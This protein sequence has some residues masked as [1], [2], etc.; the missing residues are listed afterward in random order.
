MET[1]PDTDDP[2]LRALLSVATPSPDTWADQLER[3]ERSLAA[4][5]DSRSPLADRRGAI[6]AADDVLAGM[7]V[8]EDWRP[9]LLAHLNASLGDTTT[10]RRHLGDPRLGDVLDMRWGAVL[11]ARAHVTAGDTVGALP[12][13]G[14]AVL[15]LD[16]ENPDARWAAGILSGRGRL[17]QLG[18][19][20]MHPDLPRSLGRTLLSMGRLDSGLALV[21][22]LLGD[23]S[24]DPWLALEVAGALEAGR[25]EA[26]ALQLLEPLVQNGDR[27]VATAALDRLA[28]ISFAR[29]RLAE[30]RRH[31]LALAEREEGST[32]ASQRLALI[33]EQEM[34]A[35]RVPA[36]SD[37]F[38]PLLA[39]G[40]RDSEGERVKVQAGTRILL[41]G[42][43]GEAEA[44]FAAYAAGAGTSSARQ[45][46]LFW[47]GEVRER[48]G[49]DPAE[50]GAAWQE[51]WAID[52]LSQYGLL[53]GERL[54]A[55]ILPEGLPAGPLPRALDR[56]MD[57][58]LLRLEVHRYLPIQGSFAFELGRLQTHLGT[59][60]DGLYAFAE[61]LVSRGFP[62]QG[63]VLGRSLYRDEG[64][65]WNLRLL[66]IV[67]PFPYREAIE[68]AAG[69]H[70]LDPF[71]VAGL[72]RQESLFQP[73][74]RSSAGA[75]GLMQ[76]LEPTAREMAQGARIPFSAA[77]LSDP[78]Y[79][80]R[81]GSRYLAQMLARHPGR[82]ED[83][84][85]AYNAGPG[86][87]RQWQSRPEYRD[88]A[89]FREHIPFRETRHYVKVV[90]QY[91]RIYRALYGCGDSASACTGLPAQAIEELRTS[92]AVRP[93]PSP[94]PPSGR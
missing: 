31:V 81:L 22:P 61:A 71:L 9:L 25:R 6:E 63:V 39:I 38:G 80:A 19:A 48:A 84:L 46:A 36:T 70:G 3:L 29:G 57:A 34:G 85:A 30:A 75:V 53:A 55:P 21:R 7:G 28:G 5:A 60:E 47:L 66:R 26:E 17:D 16:P 90:Q 76:L 94:A 49:A 69:E 59:V 79:N 44:F 58:A 24:G 41:G 51:V 14:R 89:I 2:A 62:L 73:R 11:Q 33:L 12:H 32:R 93:G 86:R 42:R 72:I 52:P 10:V 1:G 40:I 15:T 87:L 83:A 64:G 45:Q 56:A 88:P 27:E 37:G 23:G 43:L 82:P 20:D 67:H 50:V 4:A 13:L 78:Q 35:G 92:E 68:L 54:G 74:V 77:Q 91:A 8:L 18:G 65:V